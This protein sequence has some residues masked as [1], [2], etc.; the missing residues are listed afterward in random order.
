[1]SGESLYRADH[2]GPDR[3]GH[4]Y[5]PEVPN[6]RSSRRGS[7]AGNRAA[8]LGGIFGKRT[9]LALLGLRVA[10]RRQALRSS[11]HAPVFAA[12]LGVLA[13]GKLRCWR[14]RHDAERVNG[15]YRELIG[16]A[17]ALSRLRASRRSR[18][19]RTTRRGPRVASASGLSRSGQ[20]RF[21]GA[22]SC[23]RQAVPVVA[24][25][26]G[27]A[28]DSAGPTRRRGI[29]FVTGGLRHA[30]YPPNLR[31]PQ[32]R[33]RRAAAAARRRLQL[34]VPRGSSARGCKH[35]CS[36]ATRSA[37]GPRGSA[38]TASWGY[39]CS[40]WRASRPRPPAKPEPRDLPVLSGGRKP[41]VRTTQG[42]YAPR[43]EPDPSA[44]ARPVRTR[45]QVRPAPSA[46]GESTRVAYNCVDRGR[47]RHMP[48]CF[49]CD[50]NPPG[51][52]V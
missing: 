48:H 6:P 23:G 12:W 37:R 3:V 40:R 21:H 28:I 22:R 10:G 50:L 32:R 13:A 11:A 46:L 52:N 43:S 20:C 25:L 41:P 29:R 27:P 51:R 1:M 49:N 4:T 26:G 39:R 18:F 36:C 9:S 42:A 15:P 38:T 8:L 44:P 45:A 7:G 19:G 14:H 16:R 30:C 17:T 35:F 33:P 24:R 5:L 47:P 31:G 34:P 2:P